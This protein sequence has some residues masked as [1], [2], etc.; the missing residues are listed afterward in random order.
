MSILPRAFVKACSLLLPYLA[1]AGTMVALDRVID[2]ASFGRPVAVALLVCA[3][4]GLAS[5]WTGRR[6]R[7]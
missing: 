4:V 7:R 2:I 1:T 3:G 6:A 5:A